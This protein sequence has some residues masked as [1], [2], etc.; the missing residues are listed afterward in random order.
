MENMIIAKK[1]VVWIT[2]VLLIVSPGIGIYLC[3]VFLH[4]HIRAVDRV[5]L[6]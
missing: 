5:R 3:F 6:V 1:L 2:L 4:M